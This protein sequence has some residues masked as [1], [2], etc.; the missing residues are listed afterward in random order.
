VSRG[1]ASLLVLARTLGRA[2]L[3]GILA[4]EGWGTLLLL[5]TGY[6]LLTRGPAV[7]LSLLLPSPG[8][9]GWGWLGA[10]S[11][12]FALLSWAVLAVLAALTRR[13]PEPPAPEPGPASPELHETGSS[14]GRVPAAPEPD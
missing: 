1:A 8:A 3:L 10:F 7:A 2:T 12:A 11:A 9:S 6:N 4:L 5:V 13:R 14:G